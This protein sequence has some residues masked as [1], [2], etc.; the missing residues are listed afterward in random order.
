MVGRDMGEIVDG[1]NGRDA[2]LGECIFRS[3]LWEW[4]QRFW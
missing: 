1:W 4:R 3:F 2:R